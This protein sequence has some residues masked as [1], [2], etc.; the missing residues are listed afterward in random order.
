MF[1]DAMYEYEQALVRAVRTISD[2]TSNNFVENVRV[3][4]KT[5]ED[6]AA[7]AALAFANAQ[8]SPFVF[9]TNTLI[10]AEDELLAFELPL[11]TSAQQ[12][13]AQIAASVQSQPI[14]PVSAPVSTSQWRD[15]GLTYDMS[16]VPIHLG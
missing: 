15:I 16:L 1:V 6:I 3:Y 12:A 13:R 9:T 4:V 11:I 14:T 10:Q 2:P 7:Q 8:D 5:A